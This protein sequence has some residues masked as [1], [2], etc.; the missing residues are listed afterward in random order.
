MEIGPRALGGR[1]VGADGVRAFAALWVVF[2]H[3]FQRLHLPS[4]SPVVQD[5]QVMAMKGAF[6]VSIFFVLSG[7]LLAYPFWT[8]YL[9]GRPRPGLRRYAR[10][11]VA[12]IVP[13]FYASLLVS[14]RSCTPGGPR[15]G[16][17]FRHRTRPRRCLPHR[18]VES[19]EPAEQQRLGEHHARELA[20]VHGLVTGV[21]P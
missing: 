1:L 6:G 2:S 9:T 19:A 3:L 17:P 7:M 13:G 16:Q 14:A 5:L 4:Q 11:R 21:R 15:K 8:A 12:R 10:R 18:S 20:Q